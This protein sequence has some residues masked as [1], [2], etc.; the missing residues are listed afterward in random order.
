MD[1]LNSLVVSPESAD[2]RLRVDLVIMEIQRFDAS[3]LLYDCSPGASA[4][5]T[6]AR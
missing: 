6:R 2:L 5:F 1:L 4:R 3:S